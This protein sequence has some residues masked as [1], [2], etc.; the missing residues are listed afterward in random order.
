M[1]GRL[2][3]SKQKK[4]MNFKEKMNS[5]ELYSKFKLRKMGHKEKE[6]YFTEIMKF[7]V[8]LRF[9]IGKIHQIACS[10]Y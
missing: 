7:N 9:K 4:L 2:S 6:V 10:I 8:S 3:F 1:V 5:S